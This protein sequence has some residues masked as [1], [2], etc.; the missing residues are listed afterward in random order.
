MSEG[1]G[2]MDK[3]DG[4]YVSRGGQTFGPVQFEQ[5][6]EAAK[7]GR[8]E[9]R[10]D[11]LFG[12][13]LAD[14]A[15]AGEVPG[16]FERVS[17]EERAAEE[18]AKGKGGEDNLADVGD[19]ED[20]D[21]EPAKLD[22][23]GA[24]RLG[25]FFGVT[26]LPA[27]LVIGLSNLM[28]IMIDVVGAKYGGYVPYL[29][30]LIPLLIVVVTVKRFQNLAMS[31]WWWL[32]L[33]VPILQI[34]LYYRLFACPPGYAFTKKLDVAGKILTTLYVLSLVASVALGIVFGAA[35]MKMSGDEDFQEKL[36]DLENQVDDWFFQ[37][38][39]QKED[40]ARE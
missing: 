26:L 2:E 25:Y 11:M 34:W 13:D 8:L 31:G 6:V 33:G 15:P 22:L 38:R 3:K 27:V 32:G 4:W 9:P 18:A 12:G 36:Q 16:V 5:V 30:L 21:D 24:H 35:V 20:D 19:F 7:A 10:T 14:W 17:P 23:P 29:F 28:P 37:A 1:Q 40:A 39:Q